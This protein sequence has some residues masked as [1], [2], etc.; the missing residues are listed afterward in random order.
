VHEVLDASAIATAECVTIGVAVTARNLGVAV[1]ITIIYIG[2]AM[3]SIVFA[4][5]IDA[6]LIAATLDIPISSWRR[7]P[8]LLWPV[9]IPISRRRRSLCG[10]GPGDEYQC[11]CCHNSQYS[12]FEFHSFSL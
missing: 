4:S 7:I 9:S 12:I 1:L 3:V 8:R 2:T 6:V 5:S 10:E 11:R